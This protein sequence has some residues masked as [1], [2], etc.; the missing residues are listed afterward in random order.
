MSSPH[1]FLNLNSGPG[2]PL[3]FCLQLEV[4][5]TKHIK[6]LVGIKESV[7]PEDVSDPPCLM[8]FASS[9]GLELQRGS[10]WAEGRR[11]WGVRNESARLGQGPFPPGARVSSLDTKGARLGHSTSP[12]STVG[13]GAAVGQGWNIWACTLLNCLP[14]QR[15]CP[16][17]PADLSFLICRQ[18]E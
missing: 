10:E 2:L 17:R 1:T 8:T 6:N 18:G 5:I 16:Y 3:L 11:S 7:L 14:A 4:G 12:P 13:V 9:M 15:S